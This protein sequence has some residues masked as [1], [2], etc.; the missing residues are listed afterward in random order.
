MQTLYSVQFKIF[1]GESFACFYSVRKWTD[2][3][4]RNVAE[5][6]KRAKAVIDMVKKVGGN[7]QTF[8]TIEK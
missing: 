3:G 2:R 6:T 4:I 1:M 8:Y 5:S 7:M